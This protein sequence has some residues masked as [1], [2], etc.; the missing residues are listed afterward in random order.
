MLVL[1]AAGKVSACSASAAELWGVTAGQ[2]TGEAFVQLFEFDIVSDEPDWL[3]SQW[4]ALRDA[5]LDQPSR[6]QARLHDGTL[7][8]VI[9]QLEPALGLGDD[10]L[11]AMVQPAA[12]APAPVIDTDA[13]SVLAADGGLAFFDLNPQTGTA[14]YSPAWKRLLGY[15]PGE[16]ANRYTTWLD[17]LHEE[18]SGA[19]P[20]QVGRRA[21]AG[22]YPFEVEC[23]MRHQRGHY[24]WVQGLGV[25][26]VDDS[27][28]V[29]RV[30]G[31]I[32][33]ISERKELED[34]S[35]ANDDRM[36]ELADT[37]PLGAF[38][39]DFANQRF[40]YSSAWAEMLG[41]AD[42]AP[43]AEAFRGV[44][45]SEEAGAGLEGW[46]L[47]RQPG[48]GS[49]VEVARLQKADGTAETFLLGAQRHLNRRHDLARVTGFICRLPA[50]VA[51]AASGG[52]LAPQVADDALAAL[53]EAV[54]IADVHGK[55]THLNLAAARIL[56]MAPEQAAGRPA[57]EVMRLVDRVSGLPGDDV[58]ERALAAEGS[59]PLC[60]E[61][62]LDR[63]DGSPPVPIAWTARVSFSAKG[64]AQAVV[65]VFRDPEEM[66][67]TPEEL[68]KANRFEALGLL[69]GGL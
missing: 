24:V 28:A 4:Q 43:T 1:D 15:T 16:L 59:L 10:Q 21:T 67:L 2:L 69:A 47:A 51:T 40:W 11:F 35:L 42:P 7:R 18:D 63:G 32:I 56:R 60:A 27:G 66:N 6:L 57:N 12:A 9:L 45:P 62:A 48:R 5:S 68:L 38:E 46:W 53:A 55:V 37:G 13:A 64:P 29:T 50:D 34:A 33:D 61:H 26:Q 8:D 54:L 3:E 44:I 17:L 22:A 52:S 23:R 14:D 36:H 25:R 58:C 20:D 65:V 30:T 49:W 39:L 19:A 31:L 41:L